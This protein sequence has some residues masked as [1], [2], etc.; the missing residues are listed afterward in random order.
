MFPV[1]LDQARKHQWVICVTGSMGAYDPSSSSQQ[2][3]GEHRGTSRVALMVVTLL[4]MFL[5]GALCAA[6]VIA[7]ALIGPHTIGLTGAEQEQN[8]TSQEEPG[9]APDPTPE[10]D[11]E[12]AEGAETPPEHPDSSGENDGQ[13]SSSQDVPPSSYDGVSTTMGQFR[14]DCEVAYTDTGIT[15]GMG[16][17]ASPPA[18]QEYHIYRLHVTNQGDTHQMFDVYGSTALSTDGQQFFHDEHAEETVAWDYLWEDI[19]PGETVTTYVVFTAPKGVQF[20]EVRLGGT[21][22]LSPR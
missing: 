21:A 15:D 5:A 14:V 6:I 1:K 4:A 19:A 3:D 9:G 12:G 20:S 13:Q 16:S 10:E 8:S 17:H 22:L 18:G 2:P 11:E 7:V